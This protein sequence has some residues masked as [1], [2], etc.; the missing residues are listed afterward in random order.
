MK[1]KYRM[2]T[3]RKVLIGG[4][5]FVLAALVG[6]LM[7]TVLTSAPDQR[8][9]FTGKENHFITLSEANAMT[10]SFR[11]SV[12]QGSV[13]GGF[14]GK[15]ALESLLSQSEVVGM[16]AYYAY[17]ENGSPTLVLV[18]VNNDGNDMTEGVLLERWFP[19]PPFCPHQE[20]DVMIGYSR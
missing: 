1:G 19:C 11:R 18:G 2:T 6:N 8:Q 13:I 16:R 3:L 14:F 9:Q 20:S 15:D 7:P 5:G 12:P 17:E 10:M 4:V